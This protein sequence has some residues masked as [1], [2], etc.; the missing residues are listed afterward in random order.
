MVWLNLTQFRESQWS[1]L[2]LV[3]R[4]TIAH[5]RHTGL[6]RCRPP[7]RTGFTW[8]IYNPI[9]LISILE[10]AIYKS[11]ARQFSLFIPFSSCRPPATEKRVKSGTSY[12][13][14]CSVDPLQYIFSKGTFC[15]AG[16]FCNVS[17]PTYFGEPNLANT[18][19]RRNTRRP[20]SEKRPLNNTS[21]SITPTPIMRS[22]SKTRHSTRK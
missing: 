10:Y 12:R 2:G 11:D 14:G 5:A 6:S 4:G 7:T 16:Q 18:L 17:A 3:S 15:R 22:P 13:S 8:N 9:C 1:G 20:K 21:N 19:S